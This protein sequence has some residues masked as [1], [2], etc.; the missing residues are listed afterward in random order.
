ME[1]IS[2][3]DFTLV[4]VRLEE[5]RSHMLGKKFI[6]LLVLW[7]NKYAVYCYFVLHDTCAYGYVCAHTRTHIVVFYTCSLTGISSD[8]VS[9]TLSKE[10][11]MALLARREG[12]RA[13]SYPCAAV[14]AFG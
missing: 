13:L 10:M 4:C 14:V 7:F 12:R 9:Y 5:Q 2:K 6:T 1:R 3:H 11:E 8:P